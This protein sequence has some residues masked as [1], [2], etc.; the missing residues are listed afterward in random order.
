MTD[1]TNGIEFPKVARVLLDSGLPQLDHL[2]DYAIPEPL[3]SQ[4]QVGQRVKVPFRSRQRDTLGY[5]IELADTSDFHG[6]LAQ[7]SQIVSPVV[8]LTPEVWELVRAVADRAGGSA[9]DLIRLGVPNRHV[10]TEKAYFAAR[11]D[12]GKDADVEATEVGDAEAEDTHGKDTDVAQPELS[13]ALREQAHAL[14]TGHRMS[15]LVRS[16]PVRL[17]TGEW[18]SAWAHELVQLAIAVHAHERSVIIGVPDYRDVDQVHDTLRALGHDSHVRLDS[19]Q[20]GAQRYRNFLRALEPV[21]RIIV[22][23]R[24]ALYAPAHQLGAIL[25][26]SDGDPLFDEPLSPYVHVRDAALV[27]AQQSGAG[28]VCAAHVASAEVQRLVDMG[29]MDTVLRGADRPKIM[30][31]G[32]LAGDEVSLGRIPELATKM[33]RQGLEDGPVLVQ[34]ATPGYVPVLVCARCN[35]LARCMTCRGPI[36]Q[37]AHGQ[38]S[39]RWCGSTPRII[40]CDTCG[41][42]AFETRGAGSERTAAQFEQMFAETMVVVSDGTHQRSRVDAR[43]QIV[44]ATRGAEPIAAGGYRAVVLL[45]VDRIVTRPS[46]RAGEDALRWWHGASWLAQA[47]APVVITGGAGQVV[48]AFTTGR[49][50]EWLRA[51]LAD[52]RDLR[53]PPAVRIVTVTGARELVD[54]ALN[55]V[56]EIPGLDVLGPTPEPDGSVRAIVRFPYASGGPVAASLRATLVSQAGSRSARAFAARVKNPGSHGS[57]SARAGVLRLRFDDA[58]A[59]DERG[60]EES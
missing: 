8:M 11:E 2:F 45:D 51:E 43:P 37:S 33:L 50:E 54:E 29:Y 12:A 13:E 41:G 40:S 18:V 47:G 5:V 46:L 23:N 26:W 53:F 32:A 22:G 49:E 24:S 1:G 55:E 20:S 14:T 10:R 36:A 60:D 16:A 59:F 9:A 4:I 7:L 52:R 44:V 42:S 57:R 6:D 30:H 31:S 28:L 25:M 15:L 27:R 21:P 3:R 58:R 56:T 38:N 39:C 34:V 17:N 19:R 48:R 35:D